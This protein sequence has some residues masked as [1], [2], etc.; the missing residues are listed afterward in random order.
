MIMHETTA[1]DLITG[2]ELVR[3]PEG[4][5]FRETYR[6]N[7]TVPAQALPER[8]TGSRAFSPSI[9]CWNPET[10]RLCTASSPM[11]CGIFTPAQ[12]CLS[13]AF[14]RM[15]V[16]RRFVWE[17]TRRRGNCSKLSC[18]RAAGLGR[19][20]LKK[21]LRWSDARSPR[22]SIFLILRWLMRSCFVAATRSIL[23]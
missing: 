16:I 13:I 11:K 14:F 10:Y 6:S 18:R 8:F 12:C 20:W 23:D 5:W 2:L 21:G 1:H 17:R 15:A 22:D 3:H 9:F 7:E 19:N 4:G